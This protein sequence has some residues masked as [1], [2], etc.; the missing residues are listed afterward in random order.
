MVY[1]LYQIWFHSII[2][3]GLSAINYPLLTI[4]YLQQN[5]VIG[6]VRQVRMNIEEKIRK[7]KRDKMVDEIRKPLL[8][9]PGGK[10][11]RR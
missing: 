11:G 1:Y 10:R 5:K 9:T 2:T 6:R 3:P 4:K 8:T 7:E